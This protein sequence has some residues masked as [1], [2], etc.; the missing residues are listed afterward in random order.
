MAN[1]INVKENQYNIDFELTSEVNI[2]IINS[3][4]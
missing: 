4:M 1:G 2:Q 3:L